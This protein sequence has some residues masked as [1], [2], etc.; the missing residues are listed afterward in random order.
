MGDDQELACG[1]AYN[2]LNI[3]IPVKMLWFLPGLFRFSLLDILPVSGT[4][5]YLRTA[6]SDYKFSQIWG[7]STVRCG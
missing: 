4:N 7:W 1:E 5:E 2:T 6:I 3:M